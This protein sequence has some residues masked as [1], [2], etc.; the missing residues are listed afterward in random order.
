MGVASNG[1]E[2]DAENGSEMNE[3]PNESVYPRNVSIHGQDVMWVTGDMLVLYFTW[4]LVMMLMMLTVFLWCKMRS[5][6]QRIR[7][8][9]DQIASLDQSLKDMN[10]NNAD[11]GPTGPES[12]STAAASS[13][14]RHPCGSTM[15]KSDLVALVHVLP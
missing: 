15:I 13:A 4:F 14:S 1:I 2:H 7:I 11:D 3:S 8:S 9:N 6:C 10:E 5:M 12:I